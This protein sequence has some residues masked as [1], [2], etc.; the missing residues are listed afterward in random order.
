MDPN[1]FNVDGERM[2][3]VL[4]TIVILSF[5]IERALSVIFGTRAFVEG[6]LENPKL[7]KKPIKELIALAV[8]ISVCYKWQ[9]DALSVILVQEK[10]TVYGYII[11]GAIVAGGSKASIKLFHD[12]LD[13]KSSAEREREVKKKAKLQQLEKNNLQ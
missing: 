10:M 5:F 8:S 4:F 2:M 3:E 12:I 7:E 11:T 6:I 13:F 1:L 9:F